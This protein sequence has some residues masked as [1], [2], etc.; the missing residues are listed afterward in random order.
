MNTYDN[1][2][3]TS[4]ASRDKV[5]DSSDVLS[6]LQV[7]EQLYTASRSVINS[8]SSTAIFLSMAMELQTLLTKLQAMHRRWSVHLPFKEAS[9]VDFKNWSSRAAQMAEEILR[10]DNRFCLD[11]AKDIPSCHCLVDL[12]DQAKQNTAGTA[13][14][15]SVIET[16]ARQMLSR[17]SVTQKILN[18][19][20]TECV[21]AITAMVAKQL[22]DRHNIDLSSI[23]DLQSARTVC[24]S[25][26]TELSD[27]LLQ[28]HNQ[29]VKLIDA[30]EYE[31]LA[32]RILFEEEYE[33]PRIR[34]EARE[35]VLNWRNGVPVK[36]LDADRTEQIQQTKEEIRKTRH[37]VKLELHVDLDADFQQQRSEFGRFL[38]N[39]RRDITREE[40]RELILLV[41][42][43]YYF[44]QDAI[45]EVRQR[46]GISAPADGKMPEGDSPVNPPLPADFSQ[47]LRENEAAVSLFYDIL[48]K[49]EPYINSGKP[50]DSTPE[51]LERYKDWTWH[52]LHAAFEK[53][54]FLP[55]L[56]NKSD[57]TRFF[58]SV[59]P[60]RSE[61]SVNRTLYRNTNL[62]S[63]QIVADVVKE[64]E[65][66]KSLIKLKTTK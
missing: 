41:Y 23:G 2:M 40:L 29:L 59:F 39:R 49:I 36:N 11:T 44:Q 61:S 54:G 32:E 24:S 66:V 18:D 33:G 14:R 46:A 9:S 3:T 7:V 5:H 63:P 22:S 57:L 37:G 13:E 52:H 27:L 47:D 1:K 16:D 60:N 58:N 48:R 25:L 6:L 8:Y 17:R 21:D 19:K 35:A 53:L 28:M 10:G 4:N 62:N 31:R 42:K 43:V 65:P 34:I 38:F 55:Q 51:L 26:L 15:E 30:H 56:A 45:Q 20:R 64:F 12:Y 50:E